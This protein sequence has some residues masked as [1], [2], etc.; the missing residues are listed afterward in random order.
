MQGNLDQLD[1]ENKDLKNR[2]RD[3]DDLRKILDF[4]RQKGE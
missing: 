4:E 3:L 1:K 2:L